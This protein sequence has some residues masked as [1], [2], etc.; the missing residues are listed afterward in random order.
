MNRPAELCQG[1]LS[2]LEAAEGRRRRRKRDTTPDAIGLE[3]RRRLLEEAVRDDPDPS[4]FEGWLQSMV[5]DPGRLAE[6]GEA[7]PPSGAVRAMA[8]AILGEW[9]LASRSEAFREWLAAGAPSEDAAQGLG[10]GRSRA[11][12]R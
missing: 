3:L 7:A 10:A 12:E 1:L 6:A 4:D 9:R 2:A 5:V 8:M 11:R